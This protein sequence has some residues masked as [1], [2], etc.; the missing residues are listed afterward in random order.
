MDFANE[1][2]LQVHYWQH[3]RIGP[4]VVNSPIVL[5]HESA[6][7]VEFCGPNVKLLSVGDRVALEPG[8]GCNTCVPCRSGRYNLCP[9]MKFAATPPY[10]GTLSTYY[11]LPEENC[12]VLPQ[13]VSFEEGA[14]LEPLA[15]AVHCCT[16][17]RIKP[18]S[19]MVVFGAGPVGLLCCAVG[20]AFGATSVT[21]VDIVESRLTFARQYAASTTYLMGHDEHEITEDALRL[22]LGT[23]EGT[24]TVLECTG[25]APC[26]NSGV[27][28][29]KRGGTFVQAGMGRPRIEFPLGQLC[30]KEITFQGSFRYGPGDYRLAVELLRTNKVSVRE[31]IT[32]RFD[33]AD[34]ETAF[35]A[36]FNREG[37]KCIIRGPK[38]P[39]TLSEGTSRKAVNG[40]K[41]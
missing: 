10:D 16:L 7:I 15:V 21:C 5:G 41:S 18:G 3:G 31:L 32:H 37:I 30:D 25:A 9:S 28:A 14:V 34:A 20:R 2:V 8:V 11:T 39:A 13:H 1:D 17:A 26:V 27:M 29:L 12:F 40:V 38:I 6:G 23:P 4:Y 19:S 22:R 36:V 33:F 35:S 24:D